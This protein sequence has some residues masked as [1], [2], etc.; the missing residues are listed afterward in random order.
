MNQKEYTSL[1]L[2]PTSV[3][4]HNTE[5]LEQI[6]EEY[7]YFQSARAIHLKGLKNQDSY[8]YNK[9]LKLT[10]CSTTDRNI[11]FNF[12]TSDAFNNFN[13]DATNFTKNKENDVIELHQD[14]NKKHKKVAIEKPEPNEVFSD[15]TKIETEAKEILEIGKPIAFDSNEKH[16]FNQWMQLTSFKPIFREV[17]KKPTSNEKEEKFDL[18]DKF[19]QSE[20]KKI[21]P[22]EKSSSSLVNYNQN[23][24]NENDLMTETLAKVYLEQKKYDNAIKAY[25][26]LCLKYPEKS[27]FFADRIKAIKILSKNN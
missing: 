19:I 10:A 1:L 14:I 24:E 11:L 18:I 22:I 9:A 21:K 16:S 6:I 13:E 8:K 15:S 17:E 23:I 26:I 7:P 12:I 20:P 2:N 4:K 27:G 25:H 3:N 5:N